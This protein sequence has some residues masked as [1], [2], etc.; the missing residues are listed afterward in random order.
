MAQEPVNYEAVLTDLRAKRASL[1]VAIAG[2]EQL[3]AVGTGSADLGAATKVIDPASIPDDAFFGLSVVEAAKKYLGI[4]KR[5]QSVQEIADALERGGLP[6]TSSKFVATVATML[7]RASDPDLAKVGRGDWG[8]ANW[9]GNRRPKQDVP[10]TKKPRA[11]ATRQPRRIK[12]GRKAR[13]LKTA[14]VVAK[15]GVSDGTTIYDHVEA[16]LREHGAPLDVDSL[17]QKVS[18]R[19]QRTIG[20]QTLVG[21]LAEQVRKG[22]RFSRPAP[23]V[24][25][26]AG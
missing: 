13:A 26:L 16:V 4:V 9:Y 18:A 14:K 10:S 8:L 7:R 25:A 1:D 23:S 21:M 3:Q 5:K 11:S 20:R 12:R 19:A 2:I 17:L 6:H 15:A 22:E 24:Y